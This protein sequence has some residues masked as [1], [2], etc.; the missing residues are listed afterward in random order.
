MKKRR[1]KTDRADDIRITRA[2]YD[3]IHA[4]IIGIILFVTIMTFVFGFHTVDSVS[5]LT[6]NHGLEPGAA[7]VYADS[8][9]TLHL[10]RLIAFDGQKVTLDTQN[11][12]IRVDNQEILSF[13][14]KDFEKLSSVIKEAFIVSK[15][16]VL[17]ADLSIDS[18]DSKSIDTF[19]CIDCDNLTGKIT[20]V[21][22]PIEQFRIF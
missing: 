19:R 8:T 17:V 11:K 3:W 1:S 16:Q 12:K 21:V 10:A 22:F 15:G 9:N 20:T 18:F 7:V 5:V 13:N 14:V 6:F 4:V 2:A